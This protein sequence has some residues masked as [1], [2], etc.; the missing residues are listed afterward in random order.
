MFLVYVC[1]L[2]SVCR[3]RRKASRVFFYYS[4]PYVFE[5]DSPLAPGVRVSS[6]RLEGSRLQFKTL[7][8][9]YRHVWKHTQPAA[10]DLGF[11]RVTGT[12]GTTPSRLCGTW[13]LDSCP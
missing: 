1:T 3:G 6:A 4:L 11:A 2:C 7:C 12:C 13:D 8:S 9:G 5:A 10:W